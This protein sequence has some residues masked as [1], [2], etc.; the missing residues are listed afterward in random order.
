VRAWQRSSRRYRDELHDDVIGRLPAP[1]LAPHPRTRLVYDRPTFSGYEVVL[2]VYPDVFAYGILLV[3]KHIK[4]GERRPV[5]VCQHGLEG[6]PQDVADPA[7]DHPAYHRYA[8]QLAERGF[9]TYAPQNPYI[10]GD[11]F[12][13][14]QRKAN[15][16]KLSLF[17]F[18]VPQH[19]QTLKWLASLPFVDPKRL[20][21]YGLSYGGKAAMRVPALV[22][23]YCLSICSGDYNEW[24]WKNVSTRHT[25]SYMTVGEYEMPEF[26]LGNTFNYAEMS[27][28]VCPRPFMVERGH[29][30]GVAPD[31][32]VAYEFAK[33][34][35]R[36]D[37]LGVGDR[38]EI[39]FFDG[40]HTIHGVGTFRFLH[41]HLNHPER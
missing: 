37:L 35:R 11:D 2:D 6:R 8:C 10:G 13:V 23:D 34:R 39:E 19:Q 7:V 40:P 28:L 36:Y 20:A 17:S 31:E 18:I 22:E 32:W 16:L 33:T 12:R 1:S 9:V 25:Y 26:N 38:T 21:F 3:P 29:D 41:R 27:W 4:R 14:L 15:P 30:D 24:I 5:V